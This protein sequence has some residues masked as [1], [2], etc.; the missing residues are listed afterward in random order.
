MK[1]EPEIST[2]LS[3]EGLNKQ[4]LSLGDN[5]GPWSRPFAPAIGYNLPSG[6]CCVYVQPCQ[7]WCSIHILP[8]SNNTFFVTVKNFF[9]FFCFF[10]SCLLHSDLLYEVFGSCSLANASLMVLA[11]PRVFTKAGIGIG[12]KRSSLVIHQPRT[13]GGGGGKERDEEG[14]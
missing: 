13:R 3:F 1:T 5:S 2:K 14:A 4:V 9:C 7:P 6:T 11:L 12:P 8:W 10:Y